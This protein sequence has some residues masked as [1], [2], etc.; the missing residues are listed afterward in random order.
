MSRA[1]VIILAL[2]K[3]LSFASLASGYSIEGELGFW[4]YRLPVHIDHTKVDSD[5]ADFPVLVALTSLNFDFSKARSDGYDM[6]FASNIDGTDVLKYERERHDSSN[7]LAEYWVKLPSVSS[8]SD[9]YFYMF[10]GNPTAAD[11]QDKTNVW[12][13]NF[14]MVQHLHES[15]GTHYDS[16]SYGNNGS[17]F[18]GVNQN[19]TGKID[20]ADSLDGS[21]DYVEVSD[22]AS[23]DITDAITVEAWVNGTGSPT[24]NIAKGTPH[25]FDSASGHDAALS[26]IDETHHL[27]AYSG[28]A[29][30]SAGVA[31]VLTVDKETGT[32]TSGTSHQFDTTTFNPSLSRVDDSHY[33]CAY[34]GGGSDGW[35]VILTV[36]T[37]TWTVTSGTAHEFDT[38]RGYEPALSKVDDTH[39]LCVYSGPGSDGFAVILTV[40]TDTWTVSSGTAHEFDTVSC[41][42]PSLSKVDDT[43]FLCAYRGFQF[44]GFAVILTVNTSTWTISS[45]TA[46]EFDTDDGHEP[47]LSTVDDTHHLCAYQ[48]AGD[49][50]FAVVLTVNT[51]TWTLSSGTKHEFDTSYCADPALSQVDSNHYLCAYTGPDFDG[52]AIVLTVDTSAW[53]V[54]SATSY[55]FDTSQGYEPALSRID[56]TGYLSA[57]RGAGDDG[58]ALILNVEWGP[59][60]SKGK[61]GYSLRIDGGTD[62][63]SLFGLTGF[64][65]DHRL[66]AQVSQAW[67]YIALTY[68]RSNMRLY[69]D[70]S[71]QASLSYTA[72]IS[73]NAETLNIGFKVQGTVD[74]ARVSAAARSAAWIAASYNNQNSP[75]TFCIFGTETLTSVTHFKTRGLDSQLIL[76]WQTAAEVATAGFDVL[77]AESPEGPWLKLNPGL[78]PSLGTSWQGASYSF[79]DETRQPGCVYWYSIQEV[80]T[81]GELERYPAVLVWDDGLADADDDR[82]PDLWEER[83]GIGSGSR[84]DATADSDADGATNLEEYLAGT[85]PM[86]AHDCPRLFIGRESPTSAFVLSWTGRPARTYTLLTSDSLSELFG[87]SPEVLL[88]TSATSNCPM[89]LEDA[90]DAPEQRRFYRLIISPPR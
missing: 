37:E 79:S 7:Q 43:H 57:Y 40:D 68:D 25:D 19:A 66:T 39:Y 13:T 6:R 28:T 32:V 9:T 86:D 67:R 59:I 81:H 84:T 10:Y 44:D 11:G 21:D 4:Q 77:R 72:A 63:D 55:E 76:E 60:L 23:L 26:E 88:V 27:C 75:S 69:L 71:E 31:V 8:S 15:S 33:L 78:I 52:Y 20:G 49:D 38:S 65:N 47:A 35:A 50:G 87:P 48:G 82:M 53:T 29:T 42:E 45:G 58:C 5:L 36:N 56:S 17:P 41:D 90:K 85:S 73:T 64:I 1:K 46:H 3:F 61:D 22:D 51:S 14:R 83:F 30:G 34:T 18:G 2:A 62:A 80:G 54:T 24:G 89:R 74:E 16:T 70:G 12:D